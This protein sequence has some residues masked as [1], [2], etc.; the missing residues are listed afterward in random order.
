MY[1]QGRSAGFFY[2]DGMLIFPFLKNKFMA[3]MAVRQP[4]FHTY[5]ARTHLK[6]AN[7]FDE[8][9]RLTTP[10]RRLFF[11]LQYQFGKPYQTR[12][13]TREKIQLEDKKTKSLQEIIH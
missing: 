3:F 12:R 11:G 7:V 10:Q 1:V 6:T 13:A 9:S 4:F 2:A 8:T 5:T